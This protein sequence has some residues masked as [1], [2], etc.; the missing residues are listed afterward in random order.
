MK[1][2]FMMKRP[3]HHIP[4]STSEPGY[5]FIFKGQQL[6]LNKGSNT[7]PFGEWSSTL[8]LK[9]RDRRFIGI[10]NNINC[11]SGVLIDSQQFP[12][13]MELMGLRSLLG[14]L[15]EDFFIIAGR[16]MQLNYWRMT[17][18]FCGSCGKP[19][20]IDSEEEL[21]AVCTD[22]N[23][24][25]YPRISPVVIMSVV[26]GDRI[27][28]ARSPRFKNGLFSTLAGF[29]EPGETLE[30]A[31]MR[32]VLEE[33]AIQVKDINYMASQPWPF[34]HSLMMGFQ[35]T[36]AG[37]ELVIDGKEIEEAGWF[38]AQDLPSIPRRGTIARHLIQHFLDDQGEGRLSGHAAN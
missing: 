30:E 36:Y 21:A 38:S 3:L 26:D 19:T 14:I 18:R 28:L 17:H 37:G 13:T 7:V 32:E 24:S 34:P 31:V 12:G 25:F 15:S 10:Y 9:L 33:V 27:L 5:W 8:Q 11:Y 1:Y 4:V 23:V 22:C 2:P 29:V 20:I 16:A 6:V 35:T